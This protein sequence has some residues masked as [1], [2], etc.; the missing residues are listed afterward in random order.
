[1][2]GIHPDVVFEAQRLEPEHPYASAKRKARAIMGR[3]KA[4]ELHRAMIEDPARFNLTD[5]EI[6]A[7]RDVMEGN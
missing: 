3:V 4:N 1:M 5:E 6:A 2:K 7:V